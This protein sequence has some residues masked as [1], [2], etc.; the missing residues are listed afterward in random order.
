MTEPTI[1]K[2][3]RHPGYIVLGCPW[4]DCRWCGVYATK[5]EA[6][7]GLRCIKRAIGNQTERQTEQAL[8]AIH[9]KVLLKTRTGERWW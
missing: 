5:A 1:R 6:E 2:L 7:D 8:G 4:R 9:A 3:R